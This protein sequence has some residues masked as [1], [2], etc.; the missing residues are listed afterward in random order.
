MWGTWDNGATTA[1]DTGGPTTTTTTV[2]TTTAPPAAVHTAVATTCE[3]TAA[4]QTRY[5]A[6]PTGATVLAPA[7]VAQG[8]TFQVE[9]TPD[10]MVVPTSGDGYPIS[11]IANVAIRFGIPAGTTLVG[12]TLSG[13]S[14]LGTGTVTVAQSGA[15]IVLA[16][17][18]QLPAGT[19]AVFP[20]IIATFQATGSAGSTI[21]TRFSGTSYGDPSMTFQ[22]QVSGVPV[23]G[24]VL[25]T[26][27]C[28]PDAPNPT[29][30]TTSIG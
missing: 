1:P 3:S 4:G 18:G 6:N 20:K 16:V 24:T 2:T 12:A 25:S 10:P 23:L 21:D 13:G 22:T 9:L 29:L 11:W 5:N 7:G 17:P 26:S 14:N 30:S 27:N 8:S 19:T 28:F 15:K